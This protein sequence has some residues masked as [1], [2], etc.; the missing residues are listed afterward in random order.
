MHCE[1]WKKQRGRE[2]G[3]CSEPGGTKAKPLGHQSGK[4]PGAAIAGRLAGETIKGQEG[5]RPKPQRARGTRET[6]SREAR[7]KEKPLPGARCPCPGWPGG[8]SPARAYLS[9]TAS[10]NLQSDTG[11]QSVENDFSRGN[12]AFARDGFA[13]RAQ[14]GQRVL[15]RSPIGTP[16]CAGTHILR[17]RCRFQCCRGARNITSLQIRT[18]SVVYGCNCIIKRTL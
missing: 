9:C 16:R 4:P 10:P 1:P 7:T 6:A 11:V 17:I 8:P 15:V 5:G 12:V 13:D 2:S 18:K 3:R 14:N